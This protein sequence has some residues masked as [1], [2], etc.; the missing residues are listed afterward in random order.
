MAQN[1]QLLGTMVHGPRL[2]VLDEPFPG[3]D[4][5]NQGRL[6]EMIRRGREK[7]RR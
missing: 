1:V 2:V 5:I 3:L 4:A 6:E 7:A